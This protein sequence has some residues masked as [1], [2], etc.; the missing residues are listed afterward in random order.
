[1]ARERFLPVLRE[2]TH[3]FFVFEQV[4]GRH[5]RALGLTP[6]QFDIVAT[7]GNTKGMSCTE[8]AERTLITKGTLTGV[9]DRL[10][11]KGLLV[12]Q[13]AA[14]DRRRYVVKLTSSGET[15]FAD[16][17]KRHM[18]YLRP[19]FAGLD[20]ERILSIQQ[21]LQSL[22]RALSDRP[23]EFNQNNQQ[24]ENDGKSSI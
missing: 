21:G 23:A 11:S 6:P 13:L 16:V 4:S 5:I 14:D 7:L 17:F 8:L 1:M 12:R 24:G 2:L 18:D 19:M 15:L 10:E 22:T 9:L 20:D 3:C